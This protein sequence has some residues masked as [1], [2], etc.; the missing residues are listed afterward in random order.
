MAADVAPGLLRAEAEIK[1]GAAPAFGFLRWNGHDAALWAARS[2][3]R[4]ASGAAPG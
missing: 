1:P 4:R 2:W 3:P